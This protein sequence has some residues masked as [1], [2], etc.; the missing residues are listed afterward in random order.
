[1]RVSIVTFGAVPALAASTQSAHSHPGQPGSMLM[2]YCPAN[3]LT[4]AAASAASIGRTI[5]AIGIGAA[6]R[7]GTLTTGAPTSNIPADWCGPT[8][9]GNS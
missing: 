5:G 6:C 3:S 4:T 8:G 9:C 2:R 7:I 1:M